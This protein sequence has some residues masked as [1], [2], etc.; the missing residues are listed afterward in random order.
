MGRFVLAL[1]LIAS[2]AAAQDHGY[3]DL[4]KDLDDLDSI[5]KALDQAREM[6]QA[7]IRLVAKQP[8]AVPRRIERIAKDGDAGIAG[9]AKA[10]LER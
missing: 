10:A 2:A 5:S 4:P 8:D 3:R 7:E 9:L 1:L 6:R